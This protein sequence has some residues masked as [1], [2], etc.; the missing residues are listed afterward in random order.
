LSPPAFTAPSP[1]SRRLL[2]LCIVF[3]PWLFATVHFWFQ[4]FVAGVN[5]AA[6]LVVLSARPGPLRVPLVLALSAPSFLLA[7]IQCLN[8]VIPYFVGAANGPM[9]TLVGGNPF[10]PC[11]IDRTASLFEFARWA[12]WLAGGIA[13]LQYPATRG[14]LRFLVVALVVNAAVISLVGTLHFYSKDPLVLWFRRPASPGMS[15]GPF[16]YRNNYVSYILLCLPFALGLC[17]LP[18]M[19]RRF[20]R[21]EM[22]KRLLQAALLGLVVIGLLTCSSRAAAIIFPA[23]LLPFLA[24]WLGL[25]E[26][27]AASPASGSPAVPRAPWI[28][29]IRPALSLGLVAGFVLLLGEAWRSYARLEKLGLVDESRLVIWQATW[30]AVSDAPLW[31]HGAGTF[32]KM[33]YFYEP[34]NVEKVAKFRWLDAHNDWLQALHDRGWAGFSLGAVALAVAL[35]R[36]LWTTLRDSSSFARAVAGCAAIGMVLVLVHALVDFPFGCGAVPIAF[37]QVAALG[38]AAPYAAHAADFRS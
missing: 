36:L 8:P 35:G 27:T 25:R 29:W 23:A 5:L 26:K 15:F 37:L 22:A 34:Q 31:G 24:L 20:H 16:I 1:W 7:A 18:S 4:V 33:F 17:F 14:D 11:T 12:A 28:A 38:L 32:E 19:N 9:F 13:F 10:L 30:K 2:L 3:P 21:E 6:A